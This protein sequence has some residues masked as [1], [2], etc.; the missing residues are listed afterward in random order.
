MRTFRL[1]GLGAFVLLSFCELALAQGDANKGKVAF[2]KCA[3]CHQVGPGAKNLVGP[4]LNSIIG[5]KA[6]G[7]ADYAYSPAM[8]ILGEERFVW[9]EENLD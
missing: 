8:K 5:R 1:F 6:A 3:I 2:G 9:T 7:V 4:E